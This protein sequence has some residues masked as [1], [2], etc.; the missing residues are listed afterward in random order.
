[1]VY[2]ISLCLLTGC[3]D[4]KQKEEEMADN[5][6][7][8][9]EQFA[10]L[11]ILRYQVPGFESLSL[12]QKKLIYYLS[13]A[14]LHGRD[15]LYDQ[16][17]RYNLTI[18]KT[19]EAVYLHYSGDRSASDFKQ[20]ETYLKRVWFSNGIH[21]HYGEEKFV[22]DCSED[23]FIETVKSIDPALL[24][25]NKSQSVQAFLVELVPVIFDPEIDAKKV[26]QASGVD[27]IE[28]SACNYYGSGVTQPDVE[29]FYEAMKDAADT[30]PVAYGLNSRLVKERGELKEL[31]WKEGGG[32]SAAIE[33]I[34]ENLS[35]AQEVAENA[36]QK[37]VIETL[38]R[39]YK[40]GDLKIFDEYAIAWVQDIDSQ[41]DF[42]NGFTETYGDPLGIKASWE[43]IV[44]FKNINATKRTK[45]ISD[46][47]QWFED[48]SPIDG[49]F[50]KEEVKGVS[51]KVITVAIL[52]GDCYPSTPIGIN[53][54]N[55]NW[56]RKDYGSKSV[57]IENITSAYDKASQG[58]GFLDE[59]AWSDAERQLIQKYGLMTGNLH[60]DLHECL[61]HGSGKLLP[62]VAPDALKSYGATIEEARADL[63]GLYFIG[64]P[65]LLNLKL[66]PDKDAYKAEYYRFMMNGLMT[67]LY[68]IEPGKQIEE[69]HMRN[70]ALV[71]RWVLEK[72]A[73]DQVV[74]LRKKN[75]KT[76]VVIN[77]YQ[78][79]RK[80]FGELLSEIQRIKSEGDWNAAKV[81]VEKYAVHV[82]SDLHA[83]VI[84]R[85]SGLQIAPYKGFVN[86][87]YEAVY[88]S[89]GG[90]NDVIITHTEG[91]TEQ[92]LRY[93]K[94]YAN[95]E[96]WN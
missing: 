40:T 7:Y 50:K 64:D 81:L 73:P 26:N 13:E 39:Y 62:E 36:Q 30:T 59:F 95:L 55:S 60:V 21:H 8:K 65:Q 34:I 82:D 72:G 29:S 84:T 83:E 63:F 41:V 69:S 10:D 88:D 25:L 1:M 17:Y 6:N 68:R 67:Q 86:P 20:L 9:V 76:Y 85:Y 19:L 74:E 11:E 47:A 92:M 89:S 14:A 51:A 94:D 71:A 44:N 43:S 46:N 16:N 49:R 31:V 87:V 38:I 5:F 70:R 35:L 61:G 54:P 18:R 28:T 90:I 91:Y 58:S 56:I 53:L 52:G 32:Y 37:K 96:A 15:I 79:L 42:V 80:L 78:K 45:T 2:G 77:N 33:K 23:F 24:P 3:W 75:E 22:P 12:N 93:S 4:K 27:L 48:N 66:L 57:T